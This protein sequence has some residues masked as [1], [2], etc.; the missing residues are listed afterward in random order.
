MI[1]RTYQAEPGLEVAGL[2]TLS[3]VNNLDSVNYAELVAKH[4]LDN[5]D[6]EAWYPLNSVF[7]LFNDIVA[8]NRGSSPFVAMG[9]KIAEQSPFPPELRNKLT[10]VGI[11][12][13]W[14]DHYEASHRGGTFPPVITKKVD[15]KHY[16]LILSEHHLYPFDLVYG[17]AYGFCRLLLGVEANFTVKYDEVHTPYGD[18]GDKV[19]IHV[20][21]E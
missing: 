13:G 18:H 19:I 21:W 16:R 1:K 17:M 3:F 8:Q 5:V 2:T 20:S 10:L 6:T 11:L 14:Q 9:I 12:D 15:D 4:G 7:G